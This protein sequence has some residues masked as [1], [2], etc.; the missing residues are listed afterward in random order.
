MYP[1]TPPVATNTRAA[2]SKESSERTVPRAVV[3]SRAGIFTYRI[4]LAGSASRKLSTSCGSS[5]NA[6]RSMTH[7]PVRSSTIRSTSSGSCPPLSRTKCKPRPPAPTFSKNG[8]SSRAASARAN[9]IR[10]ES[11][12]PSTITTNGAR[13]SAATSSTSVANGEPTTLDGSRRERC[14][15]SQAWNLLDRPSSPSRASASS[16]APG[17]RSRSMSSGRT[18]GSWPAGKPARPWRSSTLFRPCSSTL[19]FRSA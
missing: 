18:R 2:S 11:G 13:N 3:Q 19:R 5:P 1:C 6:L 4:R 12:R 7:T 8:S 9:A 17:D 16:R 14:A 15:S 10:P